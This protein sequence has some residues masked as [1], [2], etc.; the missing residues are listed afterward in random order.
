MDEGL[1]SPWCV[2]E[3]KALKNK[4]M[5]FNRASTGLP[6]GSQQGSQHGFHRALK[7]ALQ[8]AL[9]V[10]VYIYILD[11]Y[12]LYLYIYGQNGKACHVGEE[13]EEE[14]R[15]ECERRALVRELLRVDSREGDDGC[16]ARK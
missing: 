4:N 10:Y 13:E 1:L 2:Q 16:L 12:R 14:R 5:G 15:S 11:M 6:Q 7:R 9:N 8:R 3:N